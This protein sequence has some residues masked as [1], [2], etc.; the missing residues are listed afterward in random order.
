MYSALLMVLS[1]DEY[2]LDFDKLSKIV[3]YASI[4]DFQNAILGLCA[5]DATLKDNA[6][7]RVK[8]FIIFIV[9]F[10]VFV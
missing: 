5:K 8:F 6:N 2:S 4:V 10:I 7:T 9:S 1:K 3:Y